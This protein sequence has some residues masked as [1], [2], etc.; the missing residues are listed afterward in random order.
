MGRPFR[1]LLIVIILLIGAVLWSW[2]GSGPLSKP[3]TVTIA[4]GS[5]VASAGRTLEKGGAIRSAG[6]FR[7]LAGLLGSRDPIR[8]GQYAIPAH[9]SQAAIL[10]ILQHGK[11]VQLLVTIPEGMPSVMVR[12][13]LAAIP[14][15]TGPTPLPP[16]G[17][18]LP[19]SYAYQKGETRLAVLKRM[20]E[21]M[22]RYLADA[23]A[24]RAKGLILKSPREALILASIV[25]KETALPEER[26]TVAAVYENR[27]KL[28]MP[29][30]ADPTTIYPITKGR[31][32]GRRILES[33]LRDK[34]GYNTY[35]MP[36][37]PV[38]PICNPGRKSI[39]AVLHPAAS[40]AL[41][42]V[43]NGKGGHVFADTLAEQN[44]N[45]KKWYA[46]RHARGEM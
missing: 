40:K 15:L 37:L 2:Y 4:E 34:N 1:L 9:A 31:A 43:A 24:H 17:S 19:D 36:G 28:N 42:F 23:W 44:A 33:E 29:L 11:P 21:A 5:T 7:H 45:V 16:E 38:G 20:Q 26:T 18:V 22:N 41:Y 30:Q 25:E 14:V 10:D 6:L 39:Q 8:A 27:L 12:D 13:R 32:L 3:A 46:I 35:T